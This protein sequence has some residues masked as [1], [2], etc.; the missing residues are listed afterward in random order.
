MQSVYLENIFETLIGHLAVKNIL[1]KSGMCKII[2][3]ILKGPSV[4][5]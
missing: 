5:Y 1:N 3:K 2:I 4:A